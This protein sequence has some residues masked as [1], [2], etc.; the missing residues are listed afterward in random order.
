MAASGGVLLQLC[1][2]GARSLGRKG[3]DQFARLSGVPDIASKRDVSRGAVDGEL[4]P[5]TLPTVLHPLPAAAAVRRVH[6]DA[7]SITVRPKQAESLIDAAAAVR[8]MR[9]VPRGDAVPNVAEPHTNVLVATLPRGRVYL[10][11]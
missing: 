6:V 4:C 7:H 10:P 2:Y 9:R 11:V 1:E 8:E 5:E 3:D